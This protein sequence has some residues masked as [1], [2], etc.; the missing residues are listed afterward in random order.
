[1]Q[2]LIYPN[3]NIAC[4]PGWCLQYVRQTFG[5]AGVHYSATNAWDSS[6]T[7]HRDYNIP[8]GVWVPLWFS[9]EE[10]PEGHVVLRAPDGS[11]YSTSDN[12][13]VPHH[14]PNLQDLMNYYAYWGLPLTYLGWT[15]DIEDVAVVAPPVVA[16]TYNA[17]QKVLVDLGLSL[18]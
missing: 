9:M 4:E 1:M 5:L 13:T 18:P 10:I 17:D 12:A 2:Q 14:H 6:P 7:Q 3:P 16:P 15:E 11:I 8:D